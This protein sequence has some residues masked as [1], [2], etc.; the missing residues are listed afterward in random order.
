MS[1]WM[2][3]CPVINIVLLVVAMLLVIMNGTASQHNSAIIKGLESDLDFFRKRVGELEDGVE[4]G[5]GI[6]V[7]NIVKPEIDTTLTK[8][9]MVILFSGLEK[10]IKDSK[11]ED[12]KY[13]I[14]LSEKL[15]K[16]L[17]SMEEGTPDENI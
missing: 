8:L 16:M 12:L 17:D 11:R 10:I 14:E 9:E 7:R 5:Y 13:Y 1:S 15:Q 4:K 6:S 3:M 2:W